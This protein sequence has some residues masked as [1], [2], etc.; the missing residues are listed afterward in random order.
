MH[1]IE[2]AEFGVQTST[3]NKFPK[4]FIV[5]AS[6]G[7]QNCGLKLVSLLSALDQQMQYLASRR[8]RNGSQ[9]DELFC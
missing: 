4:V 5:R 6:V 1:K 7:V 2:Q 8:A 3:K 9:S